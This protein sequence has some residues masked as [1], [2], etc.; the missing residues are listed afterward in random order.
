MLEHPQCRENG[1]AVLAEQ[2]GT[3]LSA[4]A[5][6]VLEFGE[7]PTPVEAAAVLGS[8]TET[9]LRSLGYG[10]EA[11]ADLEARGITSA[12]GDGLPA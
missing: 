9:I 1:V 7:H 3:P 6:P 11:I 12:V 8:H 5:G 4:R 2:P 10:D